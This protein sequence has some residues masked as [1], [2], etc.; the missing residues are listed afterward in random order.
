MAPPKGARGS[1]GPAGTDCSEP[2]APWRSFKLPEPRVLHPQNGTNN[3]THFKDA[4]ED[5]RGQAR[6]PASVGCRA[7]SA[8]H[9]RPLR[10]SGARRWERPGARAVSCCLN[11]ALV[12]KMSQDESRRSRPARPA[13]G[14][15]GGPGSCLLLELSPRAGRRAWRRPGW[16]AGG[17]QPGFCR[18]RLGWSQGHGLVV[19]WRLFQSRWG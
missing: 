16:R 1:R 14:S 13:Q 7:A 3:G 12:R 6:S 15:A 9:R 18:G 8:V 2:G 4:R 5:G 17:A 19:G 11:G 10:C